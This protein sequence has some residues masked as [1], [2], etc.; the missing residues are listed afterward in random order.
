MFLS[1]IKLVPKDYVERK[2]KETKN[3]NGVSIV[4]GGN[5]R[6]IL[7]EMAD[8]L[9]V[10][11]LT[12]TIYGIGFQKLFGF[13]HY[14]SE[15]NDISSKMTS[16]IVDRKLYQRKEDGTLLLK[17][18]LKN[19]FCYHYISKQSDIFEGKEEHEPIKDYYTLGREESHAKLSQYEYNT[20]ILKLPPTI[21]GSYSD[22]LFVYDF[23][24]LDPLNSEPVFNDEIQEN[25]TKFFLG[26]ADAYEPKKAYE[27]LT[28]FFESAYET[29]FSEAIKD[30]TYKNY[31]LEFASKMWMRSYLQSA[32]ILSA[33][34]LSS[35][36]VFMLIPLIQL[37][38]LTLGKRV[39]KLQVN[40]I[41]GDKPRWYAFAIRGLIQ[42]MCYCF[43]I[44][45]VGI[46]S[47]GFGAFEM[48]LMEIGTF[49]VNLSIF[50]IIGLLLSLASLILMF[51]TPEKQSL[52]DLASLTYVN[53]SDIV[54]IRSE[55]AKTESKKNNGR[56]QKEKDD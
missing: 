8:I 12:V 44:P 41:K 20:Q 37:S 43:I 50:A 5:T 7:A 32:A 23:N 14:T 9:T 26:N 54:K 34:L 36:A 49:T 39:A 31:V 25:L 1:I 53:T 3:N 51:A 55:E 2:I 56:N 11:I 38:G 16:Y 42:I 33:Y 35:I 30:E 27:S 48:P 40:D 4:R 6:R 29:A 28:S 47:Y 19:P 10:F 46:M 17:S 45:F 22:S 52:H 18:D 13:D 21:D 24:S 15:M